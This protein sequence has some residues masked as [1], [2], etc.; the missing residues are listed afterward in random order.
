MR[1]PLVIVN[2]PIFEITFRQLSMERN[3]FTV[4]NRTLWSYQSM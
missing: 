1:T 2:Y 3:P 4:K